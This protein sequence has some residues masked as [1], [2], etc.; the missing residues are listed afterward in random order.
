MH[1]FSSASLNGSRDILKCMS[2]HKGCQNI[3][4]LA[5]VPFAF[6]CPFSMVLASQPRLFLF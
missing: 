4:I 2:T 3:V 5:E 1:N 6:F